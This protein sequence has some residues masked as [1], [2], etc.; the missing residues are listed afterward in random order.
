MKGPQT[1]G[2]TEYSDHTPID[3]TPPIAPAKAVPRTQHRQKLEDHIIF[4]FHKLALHATKMLT[5]YAVSTGLTT[6]ETDAILKVWQA[7][8]TDQPITASELALELGISRAAVS[9]LTEK[10]EAAGYLSRTSDTKDRRRSYLILSELGAHIG[11]EF[12]KTVEPHREI[13]DILAPYD[14][15][16]VATFYKSC[17]N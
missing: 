11:S 7:Q 3:H 16:Q 1:D 13:A 10:L 17:A 8:L 15:G 6:R 2:T 14:D 12:V 4:E 9:Y 5:G